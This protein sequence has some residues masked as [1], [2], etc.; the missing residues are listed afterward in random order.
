MYKEVFVN[1]YFCKFGIAE[2]EHFP[3]SVVSCIQA[4]VI[5]FLCVFMYVF[6][7]YCSTMQSGG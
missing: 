7:L 3:V 4:L 2:Q 6:R 1:A 5:H